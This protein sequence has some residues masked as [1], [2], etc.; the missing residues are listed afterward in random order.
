MTEEITSITL[1]EWMRYL[2]ERYPV[3]YEPWETYG[4][5]EDLEKMEDLAEERELNWPLDLCRN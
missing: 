3:N 4:H 2:D 5:I 1:E